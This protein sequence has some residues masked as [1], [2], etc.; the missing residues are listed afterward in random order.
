[1]AVL[2]SVSGPAQTQVATAAAPTQGKGIKA[3]EQPNLAQQP[4]VA[5]VG[6]A[7]GERKRVLRR[8][9]RRGRIASGGRVLPT[10]FPPAGTGAALGP[11]GP[12]RW[13]PGSRVDTLTFATWPSLLGHV[14]VSHRVTVAAAFVGPA[15]GER[16]R[17]LPRAERRR[18]T[19]PGGACR[20]DIVPARGDRRCA[21]SQRAPRLPPAR[22]PR[23]VGIA[24][25]AYT[26]I[27]KFKRLDRVAGSRNDVKGEKGVAV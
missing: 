19:I 11:S 3:M 1:L 16:K 24:P 27:G 2:T 13:W 12:Y 25:G 7:G 5:I 18:R 14:E 15:G 21:W 20:S 9:E 10:S 23:K 17:V 6:I 8:A 22:P 26:R 4:A